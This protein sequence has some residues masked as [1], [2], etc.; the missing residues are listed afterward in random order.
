MTQMPPDSIV[1][2]ESFKKVMEH[3]YRDRIMI[4]GVD[5]A[6]LMQTY[7]VAEKERK[8]AE[9]KHKITSDK[10]RRHLKGTKTRP[11]KATRAKSKSR[12]RGRAK[13]SEVK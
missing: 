12:A 4:S 13:H 7:L 6:R 5:A 11:A 3:I 2:E 9:S 10:A 8:D 1:N